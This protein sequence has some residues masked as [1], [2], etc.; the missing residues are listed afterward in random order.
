VEVYS[1]DFIDHT[2]AISSFDLGRFEGDAEA[3]RAGRSA[4]NVSLGAVAVEILRGGRR[5]GRLNREASPY[6]KCAE[7]RRFFRGEG[8]SA[9]LDGRE[10]SR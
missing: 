10:R 9:P 7:P 6:P 3:M 8:S 2:G 1:F 4:L 5:V